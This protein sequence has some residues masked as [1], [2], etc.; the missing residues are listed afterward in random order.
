M[1]KFICQKPITLSGRNFTYGE[2]IPDGLVLPTRALALLRSGYIAEA[3]V[4]VPEAQIPPSQPPNGGTLIKLPLIT[5][6]GTLEAEMGTQSMVTALTIM[7]KNVEDAGKDIA[8]LE[9]MDALI[10]LNAADSRKGIQKASEERAV[11]L[12]AERDLH[13]PMEG[14]GSQEGKENGGG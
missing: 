14:T 13:G 9:D 3:G 8:A 2:V 1:G 6:K 10:I 7:Q 12:Q 4:P 11:Q 5:G